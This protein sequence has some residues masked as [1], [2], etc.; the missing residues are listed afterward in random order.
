MG[1]A[2]RRHPCAVHIV[3]RRGR[4]NATGHFHLN[5]D[6]NGIAESN[7]YAH[8]STCSHINTNANSDTNTYAHASTCSHINANANSDTNIYARSNAASHTDAFAY[9]YTDSHTDA[10]SGTNGA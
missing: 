4:K 8:A 10:T 5:T 2:G 9:A 7:T 6:A 3:V 1:P